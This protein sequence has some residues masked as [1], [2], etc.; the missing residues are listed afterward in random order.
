ML[1]PLSS[2]RL[3]QGYRKFTP[4]CFFVK[5]KSTQAL[6]HHA[7]QYMLSLFSSCYGNPLLEIYSGIFCF[8]SF[9]MCGLFLCTLSFKTPQRQK[10]SGV[11]S[12]DWGGH[13]FWEIMLLP[14]NLCNISMCYRPFLLKLVE[15]FITFQQGHEIHYMF[16]V[17]FCWYCFSGAKGANYSP[18]RNTT[19]C[20]SDF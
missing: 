13:T 12:G 10:P 4:D 9:K 6:V 1:H 7:K 5:T 18:F 14:K 15:I 11:R 2:P 19:P 3:L 8:S 16:V 20:S 17:K